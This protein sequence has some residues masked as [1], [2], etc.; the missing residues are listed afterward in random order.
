MAI[1]GGCLCGALRYRATA[2]AIETGYCHCRMCQRS[3]GAPVLAYASFPVASF[4]Y[5]KG[6]PKR[7]QSSTH[8]HREFCGACGAQ[9]AFRETHNARTVDVNVGTLDDCCDVQPTVHIYCESRVAWFD[10]DD[11]LPRFQKS[12]VD[13]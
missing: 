12:N 5:L 11:D 4:A 10:T 9:I 6:A 3:S 7:Y 8:G 13:P 1:E 2:E